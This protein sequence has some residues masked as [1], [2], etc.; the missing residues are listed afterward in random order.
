MTEFQRMVIDMTP[1]RVIWPD[2]RRMDR[3]LQARERVTYL[4]DR[5][6]EIAHDPHPTFTFAH[7]L[8]P[9]PPMIFG[10][11]GED[12]GH[13]HQTF[14]FYNEKTNGRFRRPDV[15]RAGYRDQAAYI[16]RRV[17]E[18]IDRILSESP[19]PPLIIIQSDHGSELNLDTDSVSNTDLHER[20][21]ILNAYYF[22]G[23]RH[24]G[25]YDSISPVN[26]FRVVLNTVFGARLPLL[27]DRSFYS[28]W[29]EPYHFI[30]VTGAV[31][32]DAARPP[33]RRQPEVA[34]DPD[35]S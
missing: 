20:M 16:T 2:P 22:P 14:Q 27:P 31:R 32:N 12:V 28:T 10:P 13:Y 9:H 1:A 5:L 8:C 11:N 34:L 26:S 6:P 19:E 25:L 24:D 23:G 33:E 15:F 29:S 7:I 4:L 30:D 35:D 18:T 3:F 17:Q 21:S